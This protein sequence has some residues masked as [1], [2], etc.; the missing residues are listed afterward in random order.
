MPTIDDNCSKLVAPGVARLESASFDFEMAL[1]ILSILSGMSIVHE[2]KQCFWSIDIDIIEGLLESTDNALTKEVLRSL[3]DLMENVRVHWIEAGSGDSWVQDAF[4]GDWIALCRLDGSQG[5]ALMVLPDGTSKSFYC[6]TQLTCFGVIDITVPLYPSTSIFVSSN[7]YEF[8]KAF[9]D[10]FDFIFWDDGNSVESEDIELSLAQLV[11]EFHDVIKPALDSMSSMLSAFKA[12]SSSLGDV[13]ELL[14]TDLVDSS[15]TGERRYLGRLYQSIFQVMDMC[16]ILP[17]FPKSSIETLRL[18]EKHILTHSNLKDILLRLKTLKKYTALVGHNDCVSDNDPCFIALGNIYSGCNEAIQ[19]IESGS[20]DFTS[21][22]RI[23]SAFVLTIHSIGHQRFDT[24]KVVTFLPS[25]QISEL[26]S[27]LTAV[28]SHLE[29]SLVG[30]VVSVGGL[31]GY[32]VGRDIEGDCKVICCLLGHG[33]TYVISS[34]AMLA[35]NGVYRAFV[36]LREN[37][38][39]NIQKRKKDVCR[40][41]RN[42]VPKHG[43][44]S[45]R[46]NTDFITSIEKLRNHHTPCWITDELVSTWENM[47]SK[48]LFIIFELWLDERLIA[49]DF[50]HPVAQKRSFYVATR[51]YD[52]TC[53]KIQPGFL[54]S[55]LEMKFLSNLGF[56]LWDLG[57]FDRNPQMQYKSDISCIRERPFF[58]KAFSSITNPLSIDFP[59][60]VIIPCVTHLDV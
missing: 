40:V 17:F 30:Q 12:G 13:V 52:V 3:Q 48:K 10:L 59:V 58:R 42:V 9:D 1:A 50:G 46:I 57:D 54:L 53:K 15:I 60:G 11:V 14:E 18:F 27:D 56:Y 37:V 49:A 7:R 26:T 38:S 5:S 47:Y 6:I 39:K 22:H 31:M 24:S 19:S 45:L 44:L 25:F 23:K 32:S 55:F 8:C 21:L 29:Q 2:L 43:V 20:G 36:D 16:L 35:L 34:N 4:I 51:Y 33:L 41:L 28:L